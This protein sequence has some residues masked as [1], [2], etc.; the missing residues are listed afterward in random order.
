[1]TKVQESHF[2]DAEQN[3][4]TITID[5]VNWIHF[6]ELKISYPADKVDMMIKKGYEAIQ[7]RLEIAT[8]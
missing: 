7:Q 1:V 3:V 4:V 2:D 5:T 8:S 6:D